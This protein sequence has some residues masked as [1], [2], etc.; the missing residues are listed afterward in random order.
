MK[1]NKIKV[2]FTV[3]ILVPLLSGCIGINSNFKILRNSILKLSNNRFHKEIEFSVGSF[4]LMIAGAFV[5]LN[6]SDENIDDILDQISG[7]QIG[8]YEK[9]GSNFGFTLNKLREVS[10]VMENKGWS[11]LIKTINGEDRNAVF[12]R[13][14]NTGKMNMLFVVAFTD[15]ELILTEVNGNL[16]KLIELAIKDKGLNFDIEED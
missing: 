6:N 5:S 1:T 2:I 10:N 12:L 7:I 15:D 8:V 16:E 4:G 11:C 3:L 13:A 14:N 9:R